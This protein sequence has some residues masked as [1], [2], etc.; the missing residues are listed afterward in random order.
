MNAIYT[1]NFFK[2]TPLKRKFSFVFLLF[3]VCCFSVL[4]AQTINTGTS[5]HADFGLDGDV[6]DDQLS[7]WPV[8]GMGDFDPNNPPYIDEALGIDDWLNSAPDGNTSTGAGVIDIFSADALS[9]ISGISGGQNNFA[10][11]RMSAP[12]YST[13]EGD[14]RIW[15]DAAYLRDQYVSGSNEDETVFEQAINKNFDDP[16]AWTLK[17]GNV[18]PKTDIIDVYAHLRRDFPVTFEWAY[19]AASTSDADGSNH[20][21]FEYFRKKIQLS[22]TK[23]IEYVDPND[24]LDCGHSTYKFGPT[25]NVEEHG[26]ILLSVDYEQGGREA[27]IT[28]LVWIDKNDFP[29]DADFDNFNTLGDR[30]FNFYDDGNGY[31]FAACTNSV[32]GDES[33]FGYARIALIDGAPQAIF[34]QLNNSGPADAPSWGTI[35][36]GGNQVAQYPT[37]TFVEFAIN[38]TLLG[39]DTESAGEGCESGLGSVIVKSRSSASFTSSLKDMAGPFNL[40]DRPEVEVTVDN[41]EYACFETSATLTATTVPPSDPPG[42]SYTY[43]WYVWNAVTEEW[44]VIP[45]AVNQT[46]DAAVGT[47]MVEATII[48]NGISGCTAPS[49]A[50]T[51]TQGTTAEILVPSC[52]ENDSVDCE[53]DIDTRFND[54]SD[55]AG[56]T[57]EGGGG[58]VTEAFIY[59]ID[60]EEVTLENFTAPSVC[61]GGIAK[62][63]YTV[64]DECEQSEFCETTFTVA[65]DDVDPEIVDVPDYQLANCNDD[66][67]AYLTTDWT[68]NCSAGG[69]GIQSD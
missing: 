20:L 29:T 7:Y 52:P 62:I 24:G 5:V 25:G 31:V 36:S 27:I 56:F 13:P 60:D 44:D 22:D 47:Y 61:G 48:R 6:F 49:N 8:N 11:L 9:Q 28:L 39:F 40:G 35:D 30:P 43:Q 23:M 57:Y 41:A 46:Y 67:P 51:V 4:Q 58:T 17:T 37:D 10:E 2:T 63:R 16:R 18:P 53:D 34:S 55:S 26:D 3:F 12:I 69:V 68:D 33:N 38:A 1:N 15:I 14:G 45:G 66:W 50:A 19:I 42:V 65:A 54:W 64:S 32:E 21:D 59:Y